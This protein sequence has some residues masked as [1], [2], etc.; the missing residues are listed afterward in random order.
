MNYTFKSLGNRR[1]GRLGNQMW[2][3]AWMIGSDKASGGRF[4]VPADWEYRKFFSL[5]EE[6]Y[7][8]PEGVCVDGNGFYQELYHW[9]NSVDDVL[10][11]FTPSGYAEKITDAYLADTSIHFRRGDY[12]NYPHMFPVPTYKYYAAA[13]ND[14]LTDDLNSTFVNKWGQCNFSAA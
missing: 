7:S 3:I 6:V 5:P 10:E 11:Y 12:L 14:V 2:K 13:V 8:E 4:F 1:Y 9:S